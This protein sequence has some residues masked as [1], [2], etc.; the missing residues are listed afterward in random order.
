MRWVKFLLSLLSTLA[1][2]VTLMIP[3][4]AVTFPFGDFLNPFSG[5][6]KNAEAS[7]PVSEQEFDLP[8]LE[9]PGSVIYDDRR[10]P[11]I[12]AENQNDL[13]YLQGYISAQDRLWQMEFQIYAASGRLTELIGCRA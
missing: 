7:A 4:G 12:F 10:V 1:L 8:G 6:W 13:A 3:L 2:L 9:A 11:H 5:F